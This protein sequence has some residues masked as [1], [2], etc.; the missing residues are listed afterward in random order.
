MKFEN[1]RLSPRFSQK[2]LNFADRRATRRRQTRRAPSNSR[3][4]P[5]RRLRDVFAVSRRLTFSRRAKTP[6]FPLCNSS[7]VRRVDD[8]NRRSR[9]NA[10]PTLYRVLA[11][12]GKRLF[13][14]KNFEKFSKK[15]FPKR[16]RRFTKDEKFVKI[17]RFEISRK[18]RREST[19][20]TNRVSTS[21]T[22]RKKRKICAFGAFGTR[23][24]I[25]L[26]KRRD[27]RNRDGAFPARSQPYSL[28]F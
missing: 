27:R 19:Q 12:C 28:T 23:N 7:A 18:T 6:A 25:L 2:T 13:F 14:S 26:R 1:Q 16:N 8:K 21:R 22:P 10:N 17:E 11:N 20:N 3:N 9:R 5:K 15:A 4:R 24:V